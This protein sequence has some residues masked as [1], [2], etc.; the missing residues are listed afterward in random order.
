MLPLHHFVSD[1]H[2]KIKTLHEEEAT[3]RWEGGFVLFKENVQGEE[4]V[5][6]HGRGGWGLSEEELKD[7]EKGSKKR[8]GKGVPSKENQW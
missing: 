4:Q 2:A 7:E 1:C 6:Q 8:H 3:E 5:I